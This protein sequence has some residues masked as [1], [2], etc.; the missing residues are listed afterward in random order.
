MHLA[1]HALGGSCTWRFM[2][3]A[4]HALGGSCTNAPIKSRAVNNGR[5]S[6]YARIGQY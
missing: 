6:I 2:H 5:L 3:L 4:V 1:V